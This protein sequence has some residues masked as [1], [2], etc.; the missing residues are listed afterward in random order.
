[1]GDIGGRLIGDERRRGAGGK[2]ISEPGV[3]G[4]Q[5]RPAIF[6]PDEIE[7]LLAADRIGEDDAGRS[8]ATQRKTRLTS[9]DVDRAL[10]IGQIDLAVED[11]QRRAIVV[12]A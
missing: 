1:M 6:E 11:L 5:Q 10:V 9:H 3:A 4:G 8:P 2:R 7:Y 12:H